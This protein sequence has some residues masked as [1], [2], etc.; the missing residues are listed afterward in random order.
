MRANAAVFEKPVLTMGD[1]H[2]IA[3]S[4]SCSRRS[5]ASSVRRV[6]VIEPAAQ[7]RFFVEFDGFHHDHCGVGDHDAS[8]LRVP[9]ER[10]DEAVRRELQRLENAQADLLLD[11]CGAVRPG[12]RLL[13][14]GCG[15][16]GTSFMANR[17]FG[18]AVDGVGISAAQ[19][20]LA[21]EEAATRGVAGLVR[22][23]YR[24]MLDTG[25]PTGSHQVIWTNETT[26]YVGLHELYREFARLLGR[27]GRYVCVTG[28]AEDAGG[29]R[30]GTV[31]RIGR[32]YTCDIHPRGEYLQALAA[33]GFVPVTVADLTRD[34]IPYWRLR[35]ASSLA[36]GIEDAFLAACRDGS[37]RYLLIVADYVG[38]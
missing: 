15:R 5:Q 26:M 23:H 19:V 36:T 28:C 3:A 16:G 22:F 25:F 27:G 21:N 18:C 31:S 17:R 24:S 1:L 37:F 20:R 2:S 32:Y 14:A 12:D 10:R 6:P 4:A 11:H 9:A 35:A 8:A 34:T 29:E 7:Q 33:N 30:S 38:W 13:D